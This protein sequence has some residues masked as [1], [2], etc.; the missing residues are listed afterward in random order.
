MLRRGLCPSSQKAKH[1]RR[2]KSPSRCFW[3]FALGSTPP[4][5][6]L[7]GLLGLTA[8][9][10]L[11]ASSCARCTRRRSDRSSCR[12]AHA[13]ALWRC[14][15][16]LASLIWVP[17]GVWVGLAPARRQHVQPIAQ[18][19]GTTTE[20]SLGFFY[21]SITLFI[22]PLPSC[23]SILL[24]PS[25]LPFCLSYV[26]TYDAGFCL[27]PQAFFPFTHPLLFSP[28]SPTNLLFHIPG[29]GGIVLHKL[30][31]DIWLSRS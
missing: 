11:R 1:N 2:R 17:I 5:T 23:S 25:S 14:L 30:N 9:G 27:F 12:L 13:A 29:G 22:P 21:S 15:I 7:L 19:T 31:P 24:S 28:T 8:C 4:G 18:V 20:G 6:P 3:H 16:G 26:S 10:R